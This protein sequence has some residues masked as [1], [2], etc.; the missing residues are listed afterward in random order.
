M[1]HALDQGEEEPH[2]LALAVAPFVVTTVST[3]TLCY[4]LDNSDLGEE[5]RNVGLLTSREG[6]E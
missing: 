1:Y 2:Q 4:C 5:R 3:C 6:Y